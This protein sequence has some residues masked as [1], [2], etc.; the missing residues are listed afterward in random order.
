MGA[1]RFDRRAQARR[2][3][4]YDDGFG[5]VY[6]WVDHGDPVWIALAQI[7]DTEKWQ[8]AQV[9]A[10]VTARIRLRW[11]AFAAGITPL[12]RIRCEGLEYD[13]TGIK[14]IGRREVV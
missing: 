4:E 11:S 14:E 10:T 5:T 3:E 8:A 6:R 12:D 2:Y 9:Q 13:I 1:G 7:S